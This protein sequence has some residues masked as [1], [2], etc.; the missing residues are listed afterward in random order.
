VYGVEPAAGDDGRQSL[1]RGERVRIPVPATIADGAQTQQLGA[2]T[3]PIIRAGVT[4]I[5]AV[6]DAAL[7]DAMR[8]LAGTMKLLVEPTGALGFAGARS[9]GGALRGR[10][11]GIILSGGN[12][13]LGGFATLLA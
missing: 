8:L 7:V 13:D 6:E 11:V 4:D 10:R 9:L 2:L 3:F 1:R 5:L 12:I